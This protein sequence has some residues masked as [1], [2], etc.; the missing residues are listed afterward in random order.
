MAV[1]KELEKKSILFL[2]W[3]WYFFY[4]PKEILRIWKNFIKFGLNYFSLPLLFKTYFSHWHGY[5]WFYTKRGLDIGH[6]L[7]VKFSNFISR[8]IGAF[9]RTFIIFFGLIFE[10]IVL[11]LG[12]IFLIGWL[13][14]PLILVFSLLYGLNL[15]L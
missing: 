3:E 6:F 12:P 4:M 11:I 13:L 5:R 1:L 15:L 14:S 2:W 10:A 9:I 8:I 7:E